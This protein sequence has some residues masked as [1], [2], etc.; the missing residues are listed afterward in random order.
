[1]PDTGPAWLYE[2]GIGEARA[3]L[4][5]DDQIVEAAIELDTEALK[6]GLIARA[7]LVELLPGRRGR[8]TLDGGEALIN[9][10][11]PGITQGASLT[12]E[13]VR[14]ALP[15]AGRAKLA[16]AVPSYLPP[17]PA[18]TLYER[19]VVTGLPVLSPRSHETDALEA[20]G[21]SEL[22]DEAVSGEIVF[23]LGAL[24]LSPTPAMT[25]FDV[26][27]APPLD[28]L[29]IA[30]AHAVARA[31]RR[32]GIGGSIGIDFPTIGGKAQRNAVAAAIDE[33][34]PQPFERTAMNGFGFLQIVRPRPRASIPEILR[35]DP[36]GATARATLRTLERTPPTA[37]R[38][39]TLPATVHARLMARPAWLA[40]LSR[41][42]GVVHEL[43]S[44]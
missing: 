18:P 13:I 40:E 20:A 36:V 8:V 9:H 43:E 25:L 37:S 28:T 17:C 3:A 14:E 30:A 2:A 27:G 24:R 6:V 21:W 7:R 32:H 4:V 26:D 15:E 23:P 11:P 44:A 1:M 33:S 12:V 22:L 39:H 10:L 16:K 19:L 35:A 29:A 41:R 31:I 38:R 34:L 5:D 42:T